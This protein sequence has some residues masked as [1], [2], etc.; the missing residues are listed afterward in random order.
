MAISSNLQRKDFEIMALLNAIL[1][2]AM[3]GIKSARFTIFE[4]TNKLYK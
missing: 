2:Y 4:M 1:L 3:L